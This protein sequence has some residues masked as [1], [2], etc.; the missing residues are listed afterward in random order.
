MLTSQQLQKAFTDALQ[1]IQ[2]KGGFDTFAF[3][4]G[5]ER[6]FSLNH[7]DKEQILNYI[8]IRIQKGDPVYQQVK[9]EIDKQ[10]F[11]TTDYYTNPHPRRFLGAYAPVVYK[12]FAGVMA[13][14]L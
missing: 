7:S 12:T 5:F 8:K 4:K 14:S 1:L 9:S 10:E 6:E 13:V 11:L 2:F 3:R